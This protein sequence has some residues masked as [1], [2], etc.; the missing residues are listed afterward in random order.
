MSDE[1]DE[2]VYKRD[3]FSKQFKARKADIPD[4]KKQKRYKQDYSKNE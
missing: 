4:D 3:S 1:V 2:L